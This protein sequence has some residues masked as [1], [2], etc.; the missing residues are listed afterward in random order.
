VWAAP[1]LAALLWHGVS[2]SCRLGCDYLLSLCLL[3]NVILAA[4]IAARSG[5]LI[6]V[7][8]GWALIALPLWVYH[9]LRTG[10]VAPSSIALHA[11]GVGIGFLATRRSAV[12]AGLALVAIPVG[13]LSLLL[14]RLFTRP[15]LN[16]NAAFRVQDGW[17]SLFANYVVYLLVQVAAYS[18]L[19]SLVPKLSGTA[20]RTEE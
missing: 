6:G 17:T 3:A 15:E 12:P 4:G 10:S 11:T 13:L 14:A 9:C 19:F 16:I 5:L 7:G 8:F 1:V 18:I 2:V 20:R